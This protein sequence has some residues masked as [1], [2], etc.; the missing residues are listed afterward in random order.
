[1]GGL[2][3]PIHRSAIPVRQQI[4]PTRI[5]FFD[6]VNLP[7][8]FP[9]LEIGLSPYRVG[10]ERVFL[11]I[12]QLRDIVFLDEFRTVPG[13]VLV[14]RSGRS[15]VTPIYSVPFRLLARM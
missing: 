2:D 13:R 15:Y 4:A 7:A 9:A 5:V 11:E 14:M 12:D 3:P 8:P 10:V 6:Q 1:M